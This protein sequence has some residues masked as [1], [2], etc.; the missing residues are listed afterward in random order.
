VKPDPQRVLDVTAAHLM[1]R[2]APVLPA[3]SYEQSSVAGLAALL[4]GAREEFE[5]AAAR[6]VDENAELRALFDRG[7]AA[8]ED[9]DLAARLRSAAA[10]ADPGLLVAELEAENSALRSLLIELHAHVETLDSAAARGIDREIWRELVV[11][12]ERRKLSLGVF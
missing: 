9:E 10:G 12:T 4:M 8:V 11:S 7:A 2:T 6:R 3:G 1:V 5:R